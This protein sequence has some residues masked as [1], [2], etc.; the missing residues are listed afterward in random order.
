[1]DHHFQSLIRFPL[2]ATG[3][4]PG[5]GFGITRFR[6]SKGSDL[7]RASKRQDLTPAFLSDSGISLSLEH[8]KGTDLFFISTSR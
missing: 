4:V 2:N 6:A 7:R 8:E 1:M 3:A 5:S